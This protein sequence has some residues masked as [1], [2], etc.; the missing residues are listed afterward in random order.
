MYL[1]W[2]EKC[3]P[4]PENPVPI[5]LKFG[6]LGLSML[7]YDYIAVASHGHVI[8]ISN[9]FYQLPTRKVNGEVGKKL[10]IWKLLPIP[11]L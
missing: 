3:A 8:I 10:E 7:P 9:A 11:L 4:D 2:A 1:R 6:K 5:G